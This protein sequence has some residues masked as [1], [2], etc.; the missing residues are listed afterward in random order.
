VTQIKSDIPSDIGLEQGFCSKSICLSE[1]WKQLKS[2][3]FWYESTE[4]L[5]YSSE[6]VRF[7]FKTI[8]EVMKDKVKLILCLGR[9]S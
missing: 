1:L 9:V 6:S 5:W 4:R 3:H 2:H 8:L 7:L